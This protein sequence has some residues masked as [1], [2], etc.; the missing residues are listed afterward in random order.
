MYRMQ[1]LKEESPLKKKNAQVMGAE[2][3]MLPDYTYSKTHHRGALPPISNNSP[4]KKV[5]F[6]KYNIWCMYCTMI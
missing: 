2:P 3:A 6:Q 4:A 5:S 1:L